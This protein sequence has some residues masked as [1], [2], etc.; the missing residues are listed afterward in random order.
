MMKIAIDAFPAMV[1][2]SGIG[3]YTMHLISMMAAL[4]P[5]NDYYL[6]DP[7]FGRS[8]MTV[9]RMDKELRNAKDF[10]R[11]SGVPFPFV[12]LARLFFFVGKVLSGKLATLREVDIYF[13][14]DYRAVF[15][16]GMKTAIV[17]HDMVHE[18]YPEFIEERTLRYLRRNLRDL[19]GRSD[20]LIADS[21]STRK[22]IVAHLDVPSGKVRVVHLGVDKRF[23]PINDP[24]RLAAVRKRYA[25]PERFILYTGTVEPRK[26]IEGLIRAYAMLYGEDNIPQHLVIAG[27][28]GW[29]TKAV[30]P[31]IRSFD[32]NERVRFTGYVKEDDLPAVYSLG[33]LFVFPSFYEGFGLPVLEAMACGVPVVT[34]NVSS[35]PEV[36]GD[37]AVP[38]DP[39]SVEDIARGMRL[40][41]YDDDMRAACIEKGLERA[42][43]FTWEKCARETMAALEELVPDR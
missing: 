16:E 28:A 1:R 9:V 38:V 18:I 30:P 24:G 8:A 31:L 43:L 12:T 23:K 7:L 6:C 2:R 4:A 40:L 36:A 27:G 32:I 29:K 17:I 33:D 39:H 15:R 25:L 42:R 35:L 34:S 20:L 13:G 11:I 14:T 22:D 41:L 10:F 26:N 37:A 19:A 5:Q 21:E 3:Y